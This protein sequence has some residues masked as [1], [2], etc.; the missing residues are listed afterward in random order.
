M[1][2][3]T[4]RKITSLSLLTILLTSTAAFAMPNVLPAAHASTNANLFVSAENSQWNNYFAGPQVIQVVVSDPDIQRLD[5]A[6]GEPIVT[7]NGKR[8]HMAQ[9]TDGNWYAYFADRNAALNGD[10]TSGAKGKGLDFGGFCGSANGVAAIGLDQSE[11]KGFAIARTNGATG[12]VNGTQGGNSVAGTAC[13]TAVTGGALSNH[14]VRENKTLNTQAPGGKVGQIV[15]PAS[16][17]AFEAAWPV[18]QL[19]DFGGGSGTPATVTVDYQKA[20]GDQIVNLTFDRIP[21]SLIT[22]S[23]DRT[24]YPTNSQVFVQIGD[25]QL[26]IDPTEEDSW[27]WGANATNSTLYYMAF[28]RNGGT[29]ADGTAGMQN[30]MGNV[31]SNAFFMFNHNGKFTLDPAAQG[32]PIVDFQ[33]N[34]KEKLTNILTGGSVGKTNAVRTNSIGINSAPV[35]FIE[36]G[37]VNTGSFVTWDGSK[38]SDL[39]T[40]NTLAIRGQSAVI[41]YNNISTS[42]VGGFGFAT[43]SVSATNNTWSS[44]QRIPV[45]LVDSDSNQNSKITEHRD[46]LNPNIYNSATGGVPAMTIGNPFSL[47]NGATNDIALFIRNS[48]SGLVQ[49]SVRG[50]FAVVATGIH[51]NTSNTTSTTVNADGVNVEHVALVTPTTGTTNSTFK[52]TRTGGIIVDSSKTVTQLLSSIHDD[53]A[54]DTEKFRGFNF[55]NYDLRS[56][57]TNATSSLGNVGIYLVTNPAGTGI[58]TAGGKLVGNGV[59]FKF[60]S[61]ANSTS[62]QDFINLNGTALITGDKQGSQFTPGKVA[63]GTRIT[64]NLFHNIAKTASVGLFFNF[65]NPTTLDTSVKPVPKRSPE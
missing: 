6:Y 35:T 2:N 50:Q 48:T 62:L 4:L 17:V 43:L 56:L 61:L 30:L 51:A 49:S 36:G 16:G 27:T 57:G 26:N 28:N 44:G 52:I 45:T 10:S 40:E 22:S 38:K 12:V 15:P 11:T 7:I 53:L 21:S 19:Y 46:L 13:T 55:I 65:T 34:G 63:N 1:Y 64:L 32:V 42:I 18:I 9:T 60:T 20:G 33:A 23:V 29:D 24:A 47:A 31:T 3:N 5:Q 41:F 54:N 37:G 25:P 39:L 8:L 59:G 58:L 14:V